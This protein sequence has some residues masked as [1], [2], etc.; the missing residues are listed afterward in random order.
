MHRVSS[1]LHLRK[2][3]NSIFQRIIQKKNRKVTWFVC[4]LVSSSPVDNCQT[5]PVVV[6]SL[7]KSL[8]S[9]E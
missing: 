3:E 8:F 1:D 9:I 6:I 2:L 4:G 7:S 5:R